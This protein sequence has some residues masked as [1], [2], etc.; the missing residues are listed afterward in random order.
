LQLKE[1]ITHR[2]RFDEINKALD[3]VREGSAGRCM[4]S[5]S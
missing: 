4:L 1:Q 5:M 2:F 3:T